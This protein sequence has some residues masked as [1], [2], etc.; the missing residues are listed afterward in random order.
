[1][2]EALRRDT[3]EVGARWRFVAEVTADGEAEQLSRIL[4][5]LANPER[6]DA[7]V[8]AALLRRW[9]DDA[10]RAHKLA[11]VRD[12][13]AEALI[14]LADAID[15]WRARGNLTRDAAAWIVHRVR[16]SPPLRSCTTLDRRDIE[17]RDA[18]AAVQQALSD[19]LYKD[20]RT[21]VRACMRA[22]GCPPAV[23]RNLFAGE[24]VKRSRTKS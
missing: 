4:D 12:A 7:D 9:A 1:M 6:V 8:R 24:A 5:V 15:A 11:V 10:R 16:C 23:A 3:A 2:R 19:N 14:E 17:A 22:L 20:S 18:I 21:I 13:R